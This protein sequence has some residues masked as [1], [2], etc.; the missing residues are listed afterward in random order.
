VC[1]LAIIYSS[2]QRPYVSIIQYSILCTYIN[3][4][5][6]HDVRL[7]YQTYIAAY[8]CVV[9]AYLY[10]T[11]IVAVC[12]RK[13]LLRLVEKISSNI[14]FPLFCRLG[15]CIIM[16]VGIYT[17]IIIYTCVFVTVTTLGCPLVSLA[18]SLLR[19][20][21]TSAPAS[22][23]AEDARIKRVRDDIHFIGTILCTVNYTYSI[24]TYYLFH[25]GHCH[26]INIYG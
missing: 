18:R 23:M 13:I 6:I 9:D 2:I 8:V 19:H 7:L 14:I 10:I 15:M 26:H 21:V 17:Y 20:T 11:H 1:V 5:N 4:D 3:A 12:R 24:Y 25:I 22:T 16:R